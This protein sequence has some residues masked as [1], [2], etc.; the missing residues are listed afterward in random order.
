M[1]PNFNDF[2]GLLVISWVFIYLANY[3]LA[4]ALSFFYGLDDPNRIKVDFKQK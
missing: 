2:I 4:G 1:T 3:I